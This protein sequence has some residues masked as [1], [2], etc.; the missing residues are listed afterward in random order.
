M[1]ELDHLKYEGNKVPGIIRWLWLIGMIGLIAYLI[2]YALPDL[3]RWIK[4][5]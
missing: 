5:W 3:Q 1:S 4:N 2:A